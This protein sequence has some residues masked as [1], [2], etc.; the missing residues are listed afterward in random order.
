MY[1]ND[2]KSMVERRA[3]R[4]VHT[5]VLI[6]G[7]GG[8]GL[9]AAIELHDHNV[10]ILI[11]GKCKKRDAHTIL[12]TGGINAALGNMDPQDSW[13]LHAADTIKDGC[14]IND[15]VGVK[16]LCKNASRA[17]KELATWGTPFHR[18]K[19]GRIT[20]R[21]FGAA[22]YRRACFIGDET[23][24]AI[25]NTLV[26]QVLKRHIRFKSETYILSLL[27][28]K[29]K[30][31]GALGLDIKRGELVCFHAKVIILATGGHSRMFK[32]SSSRFWE[33]NG[34][35]IALAAQ[36]GATFMDME[37]FQFHPTGM[38]YPSE[39]EG[40]LVTEAVRGEGGVL[41]NA[42]GE[43][44]MKHYDSKRMELSA[45]DIVARAVYTEVEKG[46]G[47]KHG[48]VWLDISHKPKAYILKRLPKM[49]RQFK[50]YAHLDISKERMEV[51]PTAHYS[52]GGIWTNP[53]TGKTTIPHLFAI[54]EVTAG[55]HGANRLGGNSLLELM[56]FG[57]LT[58]QSIQKELKK[59]SWAPLD[60]NQMK[61]CMEEI[62]HLFSEQG[63][64]PITVKKEIQQIMW[65]RA[66][67]V[68]TEQQMKHALQEL[69]R[70]KRKKFTI[71]QT[72]KMNE[73]LIAT[74]DIRNMLPTCE[75]ILH[76]ALA[77]KESRGAHYRLD[78]PQTKKEWKKNVI[79]TLTKKGFKLATRPVPS[80]P[81]EIK[82]YVRGN[83]LVAHLLE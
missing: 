80:I 6:I 46:H 77:R 16:L 82:R 68:R 61:A 59:I 22:T 43:R 67:V 48:G 50:Q 74:L 26:N 62:D 54:G 29:G 81:R 27:T 13:Q 10:D 19:D 5:E 30:V 24:K 53:T 75:L 28:H 32:R 39:A 4:K 71:K 60:I 2:E 35:G 20:Q 38:V 47:T 65:E 63:E 45:R 76:S 55:I 57:R 52:M 78:Y 79:C 12:A 44:F 9:R 33:N 34:D 64:N 51:A 70:Y 18:E 58:A 8:A 21:F 73:E 72:L 11:V 56:V 7:S 49:Y 23:G 41:T 37:M 17:I 3:M 15:T 31:N 25:L 83:K 1:S 69:Q 66:G 14:Y 42:K 40:I 36:C